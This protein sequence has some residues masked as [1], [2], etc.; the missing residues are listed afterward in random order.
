MSTWQQFYQAVRDPSWPDCG[1]E[2]HYPL[3]P[4]HIRQECETVHGYVP[5]S[6]ALPEQPQ[7]VH[8]ISAVPEDLLQV[9]IRETQTINWKQVQPERYAQLNFDKV[10]NRSLNTQLLSQTAVLFLR[11]HKLSLSA[12]STKLHEFQDN[13]ESQNTEWQQQLPAATNLMHWAQQQMN[14]KAI[15]NSFLSCMFPGGLIDLHTDPGK[16]FETY[17]RF[18]IPLVTNNRVVFSRANGQ[19]EH[20]PVGQMYRLNNLAWHKVENQ[21]TEQRIHLVVDLLLDRPNSVIGTT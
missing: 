7:L 9:A 14:A 18:H 12:D 2:D 3:L 1:T 20:M 11:T 6:F 19:Q 10:H 17:S 8:V 5:G 21:G 15:G 13:L 16:Y 4:D